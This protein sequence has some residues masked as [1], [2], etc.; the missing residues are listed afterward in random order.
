MFYILIFNRSS[1]LLNF[2]RKR[3]KKER[4]WKRKER[5]RKTRG[6]SEKQDGWQIRKEIGKEKDE[7]L[8]LKAPEFYPCFSKQKINTKYGSSHLRMNG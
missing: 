8:I 7:E 1:F 4:N 3:V 5:K 2:Q 6:T